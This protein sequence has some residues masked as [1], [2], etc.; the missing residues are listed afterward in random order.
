MT[1]TQIA[2][3]WGLAV[4]VV[5]VFA[6]LSRVISHSVQDDAATAAQPQETHALAANPQSARALYPL[7]DQ[8]ARSWREDARLISAM[9]SWPDVR[10]EDLVEPQGWTFQFYSPDSQHIYVVTVSGS[11]VVPIRQGLSPYPLPSASAEDWQVDSP[12]ALTAWLNEGGSAFLRTHPTVDLSV[13]LRPVEEGRL[14]WI[15]SGVVRDS[16]TVHVVRVNAESGQ[17]LK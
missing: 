8:A 17:V 1:K 3:L 12:Q 10:V 14:E 15:V 9:V 7:A 13:R 5:V 16:Q 4:L 6:I 2:I 11:R